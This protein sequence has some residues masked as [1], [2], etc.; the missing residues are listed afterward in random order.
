MGAQIE[1]P[2][3]HS[4]A[5]CSAAIA[6]GVYPQL[7]A[8]AH[9]GRV[10]GI[11]E[12]ERARL[13]HESLGLAVLDMAQVTALRTLLVEFRNLRIPALVLKGLAM[14]Q[15]HY[16]PTSHRHRSD[17]DLYIN[18]Q[19]IGRVREALKGQQYSL[20]DQELDNPTV[21]QF[22]AVLNPASACPVHL[23]FHWA[24]SNRTLF[25]DKLDFE[26]ALEQAQPVPALGHFA[27]ALSNPMLLVHACFH[28]IAH[29][30]NRQNNRLFWLNDIRLLLEN[31]SD[32]EREKLVLLARQ[33][34]LGVV[35]AAGIELCTETFGLEE[36]TDLLSAL[37]ANEKKEP[38]AR[39]VHA[40]S[41]RWAVSDI[42]GLKEGGQRWRYLRQLLR[43]Q[44]PGGAA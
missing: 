12:S 28:R 34:Q 2:A 16:Q 7:N 9:A 5:L 40:G 44:K 41:L 18:A 22:H 3:S 17:A 36:E 37:R 43:N 27:L 38:S 13:K 21:N 35:C 25:R 19:D 11:T 32:H 1:L 31:L 8:A 29:A 14:A 4:Q 15:L 42:M 39:L 26:L 24:I 30:R 33:Q 20:L 10:T 6:H 23:D